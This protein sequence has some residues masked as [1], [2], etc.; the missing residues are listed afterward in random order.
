MSA[1]ALIDVLERAKSWPEEDQEELIVLAHAIDRRHA[2][3][4]GITDAEWEIIDARDRANDLATDAE[5]LALFREIQDRMKVRFS[6][7]ALG[8]LDEIFARIAARNPL[9]AS[10]LARQDR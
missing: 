9:A 4:P 6:R 1:N 3:V 8:D 2:S 7:E 10:S 5:V